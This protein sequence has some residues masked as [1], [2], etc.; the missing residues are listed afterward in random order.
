MST[1]ITPPGKKTG[2]KHPKCFANSDENCSD[3]ISKEHFI[4]RTLLNQIQLNRTAKIAGL[5]WQDEETFDVVGLNGL[6]AK[7]L[8]ERH[9]SALAPLDTEIGKFAKTIKEFDGATH[10]NKGDN[11]DSLK[12]Y[13]GVDVE[14][15]ILK[16]LLGAVASGAFHSKKT[17]SECLDILFGRKSWPKDWGLYFATGEKIFHSESFL[18][19]IKTHPD[20]K[21]VLAVHFYCRGL[22][23]RLVLGK[24]GNAKAIGEWRPNKIFFEGKTCRKELRLDWEHLP[25]GGPVFLGGQGTYDGPPPNWQEWEKKG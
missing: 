15:W 25:H 12:I 22:P 3:K 10:P 24:P 11:F 19:E 1:N 9:N 7:V 20:T 21:V 2:F 13:S 8:C 18:F 17:K 4:S 23:L 14:K 5:K 6:S 16:F